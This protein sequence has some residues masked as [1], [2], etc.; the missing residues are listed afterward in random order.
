MVVSTVA[1][2]QEGSQGEVWEVCVW[3]PAQINIIKEL[4]LLICILVLILN[5]VLH[6]L[7]K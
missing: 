4:F 7:E 6:K 2:Q 5:E 3:K 1:S